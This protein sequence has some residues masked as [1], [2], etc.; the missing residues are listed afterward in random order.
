LF[1][2]SLETQ[3]FAVVFRGSRLGHGKN[4]HSMQKV[5]WEMGASTENSSPRCYL[6]TPLGVAGPRTGCVAPPS[7]VDRG[8][9]AAWRSRRC[10]DAATA[11]ASSSDSCAAL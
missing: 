7:Q 5:G 1:Y 4:S 9:A 3:G 10:I 8:Q 11:R 6:V 2:F